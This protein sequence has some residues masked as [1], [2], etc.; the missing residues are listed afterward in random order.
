MVWLE[1]RSS[2]WRSP[3]RHGCCCLAASFANFVV[4]VLALC[5]KPYLNDVSYLGSCVVYGLISVLC[6]GAVV[7]IFADY[8]ACSYRTSG[9][10]TADTVAVMRWWMKS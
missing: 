3:L 8:F 5:C 9:S 2:L 7:S 10:R 4:A 6:H 1:E